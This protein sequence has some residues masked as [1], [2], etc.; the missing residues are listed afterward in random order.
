MLPAESTRQRLTDY[1]RLGDVSTGLISYRLSICKSFWTSLSITIFPLAPDRVN[2][3]LYI[4]LEEI[5]GMILSV[6]SLFLKDAP[7]LSR[8][9]QL[10]KT[11]ESNENRP[12]K[13]DK[14][15]PYINKEYENVNNDDELVSVYCPQNHLD[16]D[17]QTMLGLVMFQQSLLVIESPFVKAFG[18]V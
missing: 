15:L 12:I 1:G 14:W 9:E 17:R 16:K 13:E 3:D 2:S 5:V 7:S 18:Q 6:F 10:Q 8:Q 4:M 11:D